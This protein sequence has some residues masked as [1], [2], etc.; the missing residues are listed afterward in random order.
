MECDDQDDIENALDQIGDTVSAEELYSILGEIYGKE[1]V[2]CHG[3]ND[4]D[5]ICPAD[6]W[7]FDEW[8]DPDKFN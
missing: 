6:E 3:L 1:N 4:T 5:N 8:V 7:E 2:T